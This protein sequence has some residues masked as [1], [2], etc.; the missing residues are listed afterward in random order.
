MITKDGE[1]LKTPDEKM[2]IF[3]KDD[4]NEDKYFVYDLI[5]NGTDPGNADPGN[6]NR[7]EKRYNIARLENKADNPFIRFKIV[8][9][10]NEGLS[11]RFSRFDT[12]EK[13]HDFKIMTYFSEEKY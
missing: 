8:G 4:K 10:W 3:P 6:E 11:I 5:F 12:D 2:L 7:Y 13:I 1:V 9:G